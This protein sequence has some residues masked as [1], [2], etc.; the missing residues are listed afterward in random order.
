[1]SLQ[2]K[3]A[4]VI[5]LIIAAA[6][7]IAV[8]AS[9]AYQRQSIQQ[10]TEDLSSDLANEV[11]NL[12]TVTNGVMSERVRSS[13]KLLMERGKAKGVAELGDQVQAGSRTAP[14]LLLGGEPQANRFQLVDGVTEIMGGTA[15]LFTLQGNEFVRISTNVKRADGGRAVGTILDPQ[16]A[17][18]VKIRQGEAFYGQVDI[19]GNPFLTG[20]EP[21]RDAAGKVIGIWYVGYSADLQTLAEVIGNARIMERGFVALLDGH[22]NIRIHSRHVDEKRIAAVL[23]GEEPGWKVHRTD[24]TP[25]GYEIVTAYSTDEVRDRIAETSIF[26]TLGLMAVGVLVGLILILASRGL[27]RRI[28]LLHQAVERI[29]RDKNLTVR[30]GVRGKDE[31]GR[32]GVAFDELIT[33]FQSAF[34]HV[35]SSSRQ[36]ATAADRMAEI[37]NR[38]SDSVKSQQQETDQVATAMNEMTATVQDVANNA[39]SAAESARHADIEAKNGSRVVS[40]TIDAIDGLSKEVQKASSVIEKLENDSEEIGKIIEVIRDIAEQTNLLALN[41]AIEAARAGE[42][43]RGFA[44]VA[45]EVRT[46]AS[47]TQQS[48]SEIHDM[49]SRIQEGTREAVAV[50]QESRQS[51][52]RSVRQAARAGESLDSITQAVGSIT[53]MNTQIAGAAEEQSAVA[54]EINRNIVNISTAADRSTVSADETSAQSAALARLANQLEDLVAQF[55]IA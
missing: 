55:K 4:L 14:D 52:E 20:Y 9:A 2:K 50:M 49:I 26:I 3:I 24:F 12:L 10:T 13:M 33:S 48:T 53:D 42:Q 35:S 18:I 28:G 44:V 17:A 37:S 39:T 25:W 7:L 43:G 19:L 54:E 40:E 36:L 11:S 29:R 27:T 8:F 23:A 45:D 51:A 34:N 21:I 31:I 22:D 47:R 5:A 41:A 15:T 38:A 1:M 46:L 30:T 32:L 16:G 6:T